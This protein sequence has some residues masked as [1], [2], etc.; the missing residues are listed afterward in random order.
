[1]RKAVIWGVAALLGIFIGVAIAQ[2]PDVVVIN[3]KYTAKKKEPVTLTHKKHAV[4]YKIACKECHHTWDQK[5]GTQPPKCATCHK[6]QAQGKVLGTMQAYHKSCM[7]CHKELQKQGKPTGPT[8][9]CND[10]HKKS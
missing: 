10:C 2:G 6:E 7:G 1:M 4:D 8:T 5:P 9:K 3:N